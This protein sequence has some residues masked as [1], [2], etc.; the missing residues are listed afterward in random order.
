MSMIGW[1]TGNLEG[2][3]MRERERTRRLGASVL[4]VLQRLAQ[5]IAT[6]SAVTVDI[7]CI[8]HLPPLLLTYVRQGK[9]GFGARDSY[10]Y[11]IP[12][13]LKLY[14]ARKFRNARGERNDVLHRS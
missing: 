2:N 4:V 14:A 7:K 13:R 10:H 12:E 11:E 6:N 1:P 5:L 3:G 8:K 9:G